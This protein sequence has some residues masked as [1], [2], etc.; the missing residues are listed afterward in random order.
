MVFLRAYL[1][2]AAVRNR[3]GP[4]GHLFG[5]VEPSTTHL[6]ST[7]FMS[8]R[9]LPELK[10]AKEKLEADI[11]ARQAIDDKKKAERDKKRIKG[12]NVLVPASPPKD[13]SKSD[14]SHQS[15]YPNPSLRPDPPHRG[16]RRNNLLTRT[17][18][19]C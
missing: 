18:R 8:G 13:K 4:D 5:C 2:R 16:T 14:S 3:L 17:R 15:I 19:D 6:Q 7:L 11:L 1:L 12:G 9:S 10:R